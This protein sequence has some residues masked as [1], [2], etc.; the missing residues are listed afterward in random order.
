MASLALALVTV[1]LLTV[2]LSGAHLHR[3]HRHD[4]DALSRSLHRVAPALLASS[5]LPLVPLL[6]FDASTV[7][8]GLWG[9]G[10]VV[11]ALVYAGADTD[12]DIPPDSTRHAVTGQQGHRA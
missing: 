5:I 11:G 7:L 4:A 6:A 1:Q 10:Y 12:R 3:R 9:T 2:A 8:W